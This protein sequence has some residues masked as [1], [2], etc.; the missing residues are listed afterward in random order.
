MTDKPETRVVLHQTVL[1]PSKI[2]ALQ[3][4]ATVY[5][6]DRAYRIYTPPDVEGNV[7]QWITLP[8]HL[9]VVQMIDGSNESDEEVPE[10]VKT[11]VLN[12]LGH[13]L[14]NRGA[15]AAGFHPDEIHRTALICLKGHVVSYDGF[16]PE[17]KGFCKKCGAPC[18]DE[19]SHCTQPIHGV[20]MVRTSTYYKAPLYC[21]GCG[22]PYPWMDDRLRTI[23]RVLDHN[24]R[25]STEEK[26]DLLNDLEY[27]ISDPS[28]DLVPMKK[29]LINIAL[30]KAP[31]IRQSIE[32]VLGIALGTVFKP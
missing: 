12:I 2:P 13:E 31:E 5:T 1:H 17:M 27:V 25:L 9:T 21:H 3:K 8:W 16:P 22:R 28:A 20:Q 23:R 30:E 24:K 7:L 19:C 26:S 10:A 4:L 29:S 6:S 32:N 11:S 15:R 18:I 14:Q